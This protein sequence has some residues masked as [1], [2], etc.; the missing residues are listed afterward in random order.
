M[1][2]IYC[3]LCGKV[4]GDV[5]KDGVEVLQNKLGGIKIGR[6]EYPEVCPKCYGEIIDFING[7]GK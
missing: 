5:S 7:M 4:I 1:R 2:I 3:D 6:H